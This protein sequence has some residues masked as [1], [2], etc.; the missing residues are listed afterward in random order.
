M[1]IVI[2]GL[3]SISTKHI[4]ALKKFHHDAQISALRSS[5]KA[6]IIEGV[7]NLYDFSEIA[8]PDFA[9]I[10]N[11]TN[12]HYTA[13]K[14]LAEMN[15]P[16]LIEKPALHSLKNTDYLINLIK[17]NN[18]F[19]YVACNLRF[20]PC[21][22]FLKKYID[23]EKPFINEINVYCGSY[24]PDW[25]PGKDFRNIYSVKPEMGGGVHLDLFHELDYIVWIFGEPIQSHCIKRNS[26][27][28][29]IE[30]YDYANYILEYQTY[31]TSIILNYYRRSAKRQIEI[32]FKEETWIIDL[33]S[34]KI[35]DGKGLLIY[36]SDNYI[37]LDTYVEQMQYFL[38]NLKNNLA[39]MNTLPES[40][41]ILKIALIDEF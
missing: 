32:V 23:D 28:L 7:T 5:K 4:F 26:S 21:I 29:N 12:L 16:M 15:I 9:I 24:L 34:N 37:M 33:L 6:T 8:S 35:T 30:S 38:H 3:G 20:H 31:T 11:P 18:V 2:I 25:R 22:Q 36:Y 19:T 41:K 39:P 17:K 27:S 13:I 14:Q 1:E 40:L 10:S